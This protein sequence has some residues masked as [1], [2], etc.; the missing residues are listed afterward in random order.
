MKKFPRFDEYK[1]VA[2]RIL[3]AYLFYSIAR[4]LFFIYNS[5]LIKVDGVIDF[6]KLCYHGLV[7]DTTAL[8][9][10]NSLFI[11]ASIIPAVIN[12][13]K[14]YQKVLFYIY[15]ATNLV[16]YSTNFIDFIYYRYSFNRSTRA[17]LDT[18]E[19]ESNKTL[20]FFDFLI[21]YWH[22]FLLFFVLSFLWIWLY[23]KTKVAD[24]REKPR[25]KYFLFSTVSFLL[26]VTL[27]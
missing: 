26:I 3:L 20:L 16:A 11:I 14:S 6:L 25:V 24:N 27:S 13:R 21:N 15:F 10:I 17:S 18:L 8:L 12:T 7:F 19:N 9:Y 2:I 22:V 23:K 5:S 1:V 4:V